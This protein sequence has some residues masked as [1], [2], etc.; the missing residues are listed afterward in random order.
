MDIKTELEQID[1][2]FRRNCIRA[3]K[4]R[5]DRKRTNPSKGQIM[6]VA[7]RIRAPQAG[8]GHPMVPLMEAVHYHPANQAYPSRRKGRVGYP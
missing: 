1:E 3:K 8:H 6:C 2:P 7:R 4:G 5:G